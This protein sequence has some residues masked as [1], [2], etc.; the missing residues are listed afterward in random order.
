LEGNPVRLL[1]TRRHD[2]QRGW[3]SE[4]YNRRS[5]E[6]AGIAASFVQE[7][8]S[9]SLNCG[10]LR[11]LHFQLPP[12]GTLKLVRCIRGRI[13]DVA[14]DLRFGSPTFRQWVSAELSALNGL[15]LLVPEGFGH[16]FLTLEPETEVAYRMTNYYQPQ[17]EGGIRWDDPDVAIAWPSPPSELTMSPRDRSQPSLRDV[18]RL[19]QYAGS[20]LRALAIEDI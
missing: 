13:F 6:R 2:D 10:T 14:V 16:G 1:R 20:P 8:H 15:Q 19:F 17:Y 9:F 18:E 12:H 3:L 4:I 7:N 5:F 11:G